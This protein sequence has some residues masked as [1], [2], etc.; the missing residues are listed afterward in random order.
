M[1][2]YGYTFDTMSRIGND[3]CSL[4]QNSLQNISSC[5]YT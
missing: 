4:D 2:T 3:T 1:S 5:N